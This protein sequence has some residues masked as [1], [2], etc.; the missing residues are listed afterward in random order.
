MS[1]APDMLFGV[2]VPTQA[3]PKDV[4]PYDP[5][6]AYTRYAGKW[7]VIVHQFSPLLAQRFIQST[8]PE[9]AF[10]IGFDAMKGEFMEPNTKFNDI[11]LF[12]SNHRGQENPFWFYDPEAWAGYPPPNASTHNVPYR[13]SPLVRIFHPGGLSGAEMG[14]SATTGQYVVFFDDDNLDFEQFDYRLRKAK[15][16]LRGYPVTPIV[17]TPP[18]GNE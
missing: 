9:S 6:Y 2:P 12:Y 11:Y 15:I 10:E 13:D 4:F 1:S 7:E 16:K 14:Y 5:D 18:A 3:V 8:V 17:S